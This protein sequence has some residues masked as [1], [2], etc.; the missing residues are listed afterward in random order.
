MSKFF[1]FTLV[2]VISLLSSCGYYK[3]LPKQLYAPELLRDPQQ[4]DATPT[5]VDESPRAEP[6]PQIK[7][8]NTPQSPG[9]NEIVNTIAD[10]PPLTFGV[11]NPVSLNIENLPLPAFINEVFGNL[12]RLSFDIDPALK[13]QKDLVTLR[14]TEAVEP[15]QLYE[16]AQQV[17]DNYG[18]K[19]L[20]QAKFLRFLPATKATGAEP[21]LLISGRTLPSVPMSHRPIFQFVPLDVVPSAQIS[22]WLTTIYSNP[23]L[24]VGQDGFRNAIVLIGPPELVRQA[25]ETVKFLDQPF[26]IGQFSTRIE[27]VFLSADELAKQLTQVLQT[28]GYTASRSFVFLPISSINVVIAFTANNAILELVKQWARKLDAPGHLN[29]KETGIFFY[30][31]QH[32]KAENLAAVLSPLLG[33][34][35]VKP[36]TSPNAAPASNPNAANTAAPQGASKPINMSAGNGSQIV[37]EPTSNTLLYQGNSENWLR[38]L[39]ILQKLDKPAKQVLIEATIAEVTL[40]DSEQFGVEWLLRG[41]GLND[42]GGTIS[43]TALPVGSSGLTYIFDNNGQTRAL[44]NAFASNT[45]V[46]VLS[47]PRIMVRSGEAASIN[48]GDEVPIVTSQASDSTVQSQGNSAILQQIQYRRTGITLDVTPTVH[49]GNQVDL[50]ISQSV[51]RAAENS[52]S[53]VDSPIIANRSITTKLGLTDGGSLMMAG[54]ID[55]SLNQ[56]QSGVPI[57]KDIPI[58]GSLFRTQSYGSSRRELILLIVPYVISNDHDAKDITDAFK[59]RLSIDFSIADKKQ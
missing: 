53:G 16:M 22:Q 46:T 58:L 54:L 30:P 2:L 49:A 1:Q 38:L 26:M 9:L 4:I 29:A 21:P 11:K 44:L 7:F 48:V 51:S 35:E 8:E 28:Q 37:I 59:Q 27:P 24:T 57:L 45:K 5:A 34:I 47:T 17:L 42:L 10:L 19:I 39:P 3:P 33:G 32:T 15:Q 14:I 52:T 36:A 40:D 12:L 25:A 31:V 50:E 55:S 20:R 18:V 41:M 43:T 6:N 23:K 56:G 13:E